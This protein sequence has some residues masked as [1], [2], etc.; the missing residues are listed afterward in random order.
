MLDASR[1]FSS[2]AVGDVD[3]ARR[4]Y[5]DVLGLPVEDATLGLPGANLPKGLRIAVGGASVLVYPRP[6]HVPAPFTILN[7]TV[8]DIDAA[9][10]ELTSKGVRFER[11]SAQPQ[12][13]AKGIH[14]DPSVHA[15][16]WFADPA[17]NIL[18]LIE[19]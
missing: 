9:V 5:G 19:E 7:F 11:Y 18:S 2:F 8:P 17:G 15:T 1:G 3:Q 6:N 14:R 13:D 16:A 12:T 4:F 10:D